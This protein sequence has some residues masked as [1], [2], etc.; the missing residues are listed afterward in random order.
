MCSYIRVVEV[1]IHALLYIRQIYPAELFVRRVKFG[2]PAFQCT[3]PII[4]NYISEVVEAV[5][6]ELLQVSFLSS[7]VLLNETRGHT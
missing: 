5:G 4:T 6:E 1:A 7:H 3:E 2:I